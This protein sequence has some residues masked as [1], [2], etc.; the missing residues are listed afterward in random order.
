MSKEGQPEKIGKMSH[1][2]DICMQTGGGQFGT[3]ILAST[4]GIK[5]LLYVDSVPRCQ[6]RL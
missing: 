6:T 4:P 2:R 3:R 1:N 5:I